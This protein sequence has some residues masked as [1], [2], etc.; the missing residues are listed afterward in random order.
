MACR[1]YGE[2]LCA[3]LCLTACLLENEPASQSPTTNPQGASNGTRTKTSKRPAVSEETSQF[4]RFFETLKYRERYPDREPSPKYPRGG[5]KTEV[6]EGEG[7]RE[8]KTQESQDYETT[9]NRTSDPNQRKAETPEAR[10]HV[11]RDDV[12]ESRIPCR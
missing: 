10:P 6:G 5:R 1:C 11:L 7:L 2:I 12:R 3:A 9:G 8:G 4:P